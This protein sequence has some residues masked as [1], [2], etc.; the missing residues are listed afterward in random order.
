MA[1][2]VMY[3]VAALLLCKSG[4]GLG[5]VSWGWGSQVSGREFRG[6]AGGVWSTGA[7]SGG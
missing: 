4:V 1:C 2:W 6:F 5:Q 7:D 3:G